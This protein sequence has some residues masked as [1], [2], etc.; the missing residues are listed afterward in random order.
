MISRASHLAALILFAI[1]TANAQ[2]RDFTP[3]LMPDRTAEVALA[4][5]GAPAGIS[6]AATVLVLT[7]TG[8]ETAAK[9]SNGFTCFVARSFHAGFEDPK[10]WNPNL[11]APHCFN[12]P[13]VRTIVPE[14][15]KRAEWILAGI[16]T[17]TIERRTLQGYAARTFPLPATG[18]MAYMLSPRQVLDDTDPHWLPHVMFYFDAKGSNG[19][20]AAAD[21][22]APVIADPTAN[23]KWPVRVAL[24]PARLWSDGTPAPAHQGH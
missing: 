21:M 18:A 5:T 16:D 15:L 13:A 19:A 7:R 3:Y 17:K 24:I 14:M 12:P 9:G 1:T 23:P 4:R 8:Y 20:F 22:Q 2:S 10:F 11:R 6:G